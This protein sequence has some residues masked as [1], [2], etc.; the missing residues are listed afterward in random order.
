MADTEEWKK[1]VNGKIATFTYRRTGPRSAEMTAQLEG[2]EF[3]NFLQ[4]MGPSGALNPLSREDVE[5]LFAPVLRQAH[6]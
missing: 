3:K 6:K 1:T 4:M 2:Q 5:A